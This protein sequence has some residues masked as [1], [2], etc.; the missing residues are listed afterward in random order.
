MEVKKTRF[1]LLRARGFPNGGFGRQIAGVTEAERLC[2]FIMLH[3]LPAT[4]LLL[5]CR[6]GLCVR[7]ALPM[8]LFSVMPHPG[9]LSPGS[10]E[11]GPMLGEE[12]GFTV[13]TAYQTAYLLSSEF[14]MVFKWQ[15][16]DCDQ[17]LI[18][19]H[20]QYLSQA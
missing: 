17:L 13:A 20:H 14:R 3:S 8:G 15:K 19:L 12:T 2:S 18:T 5:C 9:S 11:T 4:A 10:T 1:L 6:Q 7:Q 16:P